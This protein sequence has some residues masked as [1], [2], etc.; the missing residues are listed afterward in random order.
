[1][2]NSLNRMHEHREMIERTIAAVRKWS[3]AWL[4]AVPPLPRRKPM[5]CLTDRIDAAGELAS[6]Q[7]RD[8]AW[9]RGL[10]LRVNL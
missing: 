1:M 2:Q 8:A 4:K 7:C 9:N 5:V 6:A 10:H 3:R